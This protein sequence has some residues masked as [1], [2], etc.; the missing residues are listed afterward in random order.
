MS[1]DQAKR[2]RTLENENRRL[3]QAVSDLTLDKQILVEAARGN[4]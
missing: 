4:F 2:L 1:F 3:R